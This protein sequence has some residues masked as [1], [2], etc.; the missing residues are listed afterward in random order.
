[1]NQRRILAATVLAGALG[2]GA[3]YVFAQDTSARAAPAVSITQAIATAEQHANGRAVEAE[4][5]RSVRGAYYEVKVVGP[6]GVREI[7]VDAADGQIVASRE[8]SRFTSWLD[9]DDD[10]DDDDDHDD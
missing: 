9:D 4:L 8:K 3:A 6:E 1:M 10:D 5:E 2:T 7:H